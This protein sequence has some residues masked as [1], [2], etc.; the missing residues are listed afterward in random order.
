MIVAVV[1]AVAFIVAIVVDE[2]VD[3]EDRNEVT[4]LKHSLEQD[5]IISPP[6]PACNENQSVFRLDSLR[7][8]EP[9]Q[10]LSFS[11]DRP[12]ASEGIRDDGDEEK[13][14]DPDRIEGRRDCD[15]V[16]EE[17]MKRK[18]YE[19]KCFLGNVR[20]AFQGSKWG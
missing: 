7:R 2:D 3:V 16:S 13:N 1:V 11:V 6:L 12:D 8:R 17:Q 9:T 14:S 4:F 15:S 5:N 19:P 18:R 20:T 10:K